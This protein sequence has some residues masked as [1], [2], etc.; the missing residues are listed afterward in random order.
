MSLTA[1][2]PLVKLMLSKLTRVGARL[3]G[4]PCERVNAARTTDVVC[5]FRGTVLQ[6]N[7][8]AY[9]N[10][11]LAL[12]LVALAVLFYAL[13]VVHMGEVEERRHAQD[14]QAHARP[15]PPPPTPAR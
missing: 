7:S 6:R 8:G 2:S 9:G 13:T 15:V 1:T 3:N 10:H 4:V 14:P 5:C 12:A 11:A